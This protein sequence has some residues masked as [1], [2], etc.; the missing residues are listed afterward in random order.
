MESVT[1]LTSFEKRTI[2]EVHSCLRHTANLRFSSTKQ[3][4]EET[5]SREKKDDLKKKKIMAP[6]IRVVNKMFC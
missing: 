2:K 5:Y 3:P 4:S 1:Q 6:R